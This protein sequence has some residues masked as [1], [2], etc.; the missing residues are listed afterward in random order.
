MGPLVL[1]GLDAV[2]WLD[3][4][5]ARTLHLLN[6]SYLDEIASR[7]KTSVPMITSG[8]GLWHQH[9]LLFTL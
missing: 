7:L 3:C 6:T 8:K 4:S 2:V 1:I 5:S 9:G